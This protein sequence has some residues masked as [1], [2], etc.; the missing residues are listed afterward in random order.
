MR[1]DYFLFSQLRTDL[2]AFRQ[3]SRSNAVC[4]RCPFSHGAAVFCFDLSFSV[5]PISSISLLRRG[6][7]DGLEKKQGLSEGSIS[8]RRLY[9]SGR[10]RTPFTTLLPSTIADLQPF[11]LFLPFTISLNHE[12]PFLLV[13]AC[14]Q[15]NDVTHFSRLS[16][17]SE[18]PST[19]S[20]FF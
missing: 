19:P 4:P 20:R 12:P 3:G 18:R 1:G 16:D 11:L 10:L 17:R 13:A 9:A 6:V 14:C 8:S 2:V 15:L 5:F 7:F